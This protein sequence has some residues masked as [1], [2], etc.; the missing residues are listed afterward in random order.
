[1][2]KRFSN[3]SHSADL[4]KLR[5]LA[6]K[7]GN[8]TLSLAPPHKDVYRDYS[9]KAVQ[10]LG[11]QARENLKAAI[12][13]PEISA[14]LSA[15]E[16]LRVT[17]STDFLKIESQRGDVWKFTIQNCQWIDQ[18]WHLFTGPFEFGT[19]R[20]IQLFLQF[21]PKSLGLLVSK[22]YD[23]NVLTNPSI[24]SSPRTIAEIKKRLAPGTLAFS[25][26]QLR[27][28][29]CQLYFHPNDISDAIDT[30]CGAARKTK[31]WW[32]MVNP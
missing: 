16:K 18:N 29:K 23:P 31:W 5:A 1:M 25:I 12:F 3:P 19:K 17:I 13:Q 7:H 14:T 10:R 9:S 6:T 32:Q 28:K 27:L 24:A 15:P 8:C 2:T 20:D 30:V 4:S 21:D 26:S 11:D 22:W